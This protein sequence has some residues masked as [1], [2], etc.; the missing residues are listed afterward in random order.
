M[1]STMS[2]M[3]KLMVI[4]G[5][6][7]TQVR[8][9]TNDTMIINRLNQCQKLNTTLIM[10]TLGITVGLSVT[11]LATLV[12]VGIILIRNSRRRTYHIPPVSVRNCISD[13]EE[14]N[15][16]RINEYNYEMF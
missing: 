10:M 1:K 11:I 8:T 13:H 9:Q 15:N 12:T 5:I 14:K 16:I 3:M 4:M 7:T 2:K 6:L